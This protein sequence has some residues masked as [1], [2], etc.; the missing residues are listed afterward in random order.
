MAVG[1]AQNILVETKIIEMKEGKLPKEFDPTNLN[2]LFF[3]KFVTWDEVN[4]KVMPGS[5][6]GY[7]RTPYRDR[8]MKFPCDVN[9]KLD[10]LCGMYSREKVTLTKCKYTVEFCIRLCVAVMTNM[11]DGVKQPQEG[12]WCKTFVYSGNMLLVMIDLENKFQKEI[13]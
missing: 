13:V 4:R 5:D 1:D 3:D 9:R 6:D 10:V 12:R 8:I 7:V 11:I 2:D